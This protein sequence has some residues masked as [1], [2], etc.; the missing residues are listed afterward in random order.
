MPCAVLLRSN[1]L[2]A[3]DV[4][5]YCCVAVVFLQ[6]CVP[7]ARLLCCCVVVAL[8]LLFCWS[9]CFVRMVWFHALVVPLL[10]SCCVMLFVSRCHCGPIV[11]LLCAFA[12]FPVRF[13]LFI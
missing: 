6:F 4:L 9:N 10:L 13:L 2:S 11:C 3:V 5:R 8:L 7:V 12:V 1:C